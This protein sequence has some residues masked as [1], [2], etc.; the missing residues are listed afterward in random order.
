MCNGKSFARIQSFSLTLSPLVGG[1][2]RSPGRR[3]LRL[4]SQPSGRFAS[5]TPSPAAAAAAAAAEFSRKHLTRQPFGYVTMTPPST[6]TRSTSLVLG[7]DGVSSPLSTPRLRCV[8]AR[9]P[10]R[11]RFHSFDSLQSHAGVSFRI[12]RQT[13]RRLWYRMAT[14]VDRRT[15]SNSWSSCASSGRFDQAATSTSPCARSSTPAP[16][17]TTDEGC[18]SSHR[19]R[20]ALC[21]TISSTRDSRLPSVNSR[22][23]GTSSARTLF[24]KKAT[25]AL[26]ASS[27]HSN[28]RDVR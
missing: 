19:L 17:S 9:L 2:K 18:A 21:C 5:A 22:N 8:Q 27:R 14:P 10:T 4:S 20:D 11:T 24:R 7:A 3:V 25:S 16:A 26:D 1:R 6:T 15:Y 12:C 23:T 28:A 13:L